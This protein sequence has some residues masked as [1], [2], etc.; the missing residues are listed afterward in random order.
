MLLVPISSPFHNYRRENTGQLVRDWGLFSK[1]LP[2]VSKFEPSG[3]LKNLLSSV[4][5]P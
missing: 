3:K 5:R 4:S 2:G 1:N